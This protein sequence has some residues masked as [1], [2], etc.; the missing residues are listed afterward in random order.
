MYR[1]VAWL[2]P[3]LALD[4]RRVRRR[5]LPGDRINNLRRPARSQY[6]PTAPL[7][8]TKG[9]TPYPYMVGNL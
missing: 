2:P 9:H 5:L 4:S 3:D 6:G 8:G 7:H 1:R